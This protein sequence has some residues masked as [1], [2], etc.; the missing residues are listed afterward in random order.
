MHIKIGWQQQ[1]MKEMI[2][3]KSKVAWNWGTLETIIR[4]AL[5]KM[6]KAVVN[7]I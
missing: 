7:D 1:V 2:Q 5:N 4:I 6:I 3:N